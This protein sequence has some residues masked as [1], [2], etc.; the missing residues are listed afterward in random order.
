LTIIEQD[1]ALRLAAKRDFSADGVKHVAGDEW[2]FVGPGQAMPSQ[3]K[4]F[5]GLVTFFLLCLIGR[6][7][8]P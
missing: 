6:N 4:C 7:L 3:S 8:R 1:C 2:L 5:F